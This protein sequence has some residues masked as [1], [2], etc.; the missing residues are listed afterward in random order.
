MSHRMKRKGKMENEQGFT[1]VEMLVVLFI[2]GLIIAI[3]LPN[4]KSA[5]ETARDRADEVNRKLIS[6]QADNYYL[7]YGEYPS[8]VDEL[9]K[10]KFLRS[11]PTCPG[12]KGKYVIN[13]SPHVS[14]DKR[15]TCEKDGK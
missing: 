8:S 1:L 12:G 5:G 2:I 4:L 3:A 11:V 14:N 13:P 7:E 6:A 15:V 9:V 10:R